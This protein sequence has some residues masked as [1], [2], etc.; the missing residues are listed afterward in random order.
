MTDNNN[1]E[2]EIMTNN[3]IIKLAQIDNEDIQLM[4]NI[5]TKINNMSEQELKIYKKNMRT[6]LKGCRNKVLY[7]QFISGDKM[8]TADQLERIGFTQEY[9]A[10]NFYSKDFRNLNKNKSEK[11]GHLVYDTTTK[12]S[13]VDVD[14]LDRKFDLKSLAVEYPSNIPYGHEVKNRLQEIVNKEH[15]LTTVSSLRDKYLIESSINKLK[16]ELDVLMSE[17][18]NRSDVMREFKEVQK[19]SKMIRRALGNKKLRSVN[20][21]KKLIELKIEAVDQ[22]IDDMTI[23]SF[24]ESTSEKTKKLMDIAQKYNF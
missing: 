16:D 22:K 23:N 12:Y 8:L 11:A 13:F 10:N 24:T 19:T 5:T 18:L 4:A 14:K 2:L 7:H 1:K 15:E 21:S 9:I 17:L 20:L 3:D 6:S